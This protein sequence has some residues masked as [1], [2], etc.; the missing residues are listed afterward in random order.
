MQT[1]TEEQTAA[2]I[3][4]VFPKA[5]DVFNASGNN[6]CCK[7]DRLLKDTFN[8]KELEASSVLTDLNEAYSE[9]KET[10]IQ[11]K[12]WISYLFQRSLLI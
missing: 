10:G 11:A 3:V 9:W 1:F 4:K 8:D 2:H 7:G 12:A 5:S 6:F